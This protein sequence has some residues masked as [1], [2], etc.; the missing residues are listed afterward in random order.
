MKKV[1]VDDPLV[2]YATTEIAPIRSRAEIDSLLAIYGI[3][4]VAWNWRPES[5]DIWVQFNITEEINDVPVK[6]SARIVCNILWNRGNRNAHTPDKR[7]ESPNLAVSMR[8]MFY[9]IKAALQASYTMGSSKVSAFLPHIVGGDGR[10]VEQIFIPQIAAP[11]SQY[12]LEQ[13]ET[14]VYKPEV[15]PIAQQPRNVTLE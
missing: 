6:V 5:N 4:Q 11:N 9:Y 7:I 2:H 15:K 14:E 13:K 1:Y 8:A 3:Y 12:A 10:T